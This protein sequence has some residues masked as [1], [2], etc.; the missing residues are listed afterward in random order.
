MPRLP[1]ITRWSFSKGRVL[2]HFADGAHSPRFSSMEEATDWL[3]EKKKEMK[4]AKS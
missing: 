1:R 4:N 2:I 3:K